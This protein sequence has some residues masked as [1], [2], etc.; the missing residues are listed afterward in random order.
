[1]A[2]NRLKAGHQITVYNRSP[3]KAESLVQ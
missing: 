3:D 2:A 1:M